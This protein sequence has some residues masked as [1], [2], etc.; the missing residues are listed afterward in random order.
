MSTHTRRARAEATLGARVAA[1][2]AA[3]VATS[4]AAC[5]PELPPVP[6]VLTRPQVLAIV[7]T[8]A[9]QRPG[10]EA[11][12]AAIVGGPDTTAAA[13]VGAQLAWATCAAPRPLG[14]E[15]PIDPAC[16]DRGTEAQV[17]LAATGTVVRAR[18]PVDACR[19]FG[20]DPPPGDFRAQDPDATGGYY[21]P[22]VVQGLDLDV[23]FG[24]R[25]R[26]GVARAPAD[27]ARAFEAEYR[28][29]RAPEV[30]ALRHDGATLRLELP[31]A[32]AET[33]PVV[34]PSGDALERRT[35]QL[36][37]TWW[38]SAGA[39]GSP[40]AVVVDGAAETPWQAD[41]AATAWAVVRDERG[42]VT[43]V[44]TRAR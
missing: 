33:Y 8:P 22:L 38:A 7:A 36:T 27:L 35:E 4:M 23:V 20:P 19:T 9:E 40:R 39:L 24:H 18:V 34:A 32:A 26:C 16:L 29:N 5:A 41:S 25:L 6:H 1:H 44:S 3:L 10:Q 31:P 15:G 13:L 30:T 2:L 43:V 12:Y 21:L 28:D 11:T 42:G 37:V 17:P 14:E